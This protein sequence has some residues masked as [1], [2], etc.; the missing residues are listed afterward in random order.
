MGAAKRLL[1]PPAHRAAVVQLLGRRVRVLAELDLRDGR[2]AREGHA[3][4]AADDPLFREARVEHARAAELLLQSQRRPVHAAFGP[5]VLSEHHELGIRCELHIQRAANRGQ[6]V[7]AGCFGLRDFQRDGAANES[8]G[9]QPALLLHIPRS[10]ALGEHM[11]C[12]ASTDRVT[13]S[14]QRSLDSL[15][16]VAA[17]PLRDAATIHRR[18]MMF[19]TSADCRCVSGSRARSARDEVRR[20][21]GLGVLPRMPA[22]P[23]HGETQKNRA[24][25]GA[26]LRDTAATMS[27][28][29]LLRIRPVS[30]ENA[31]IRKRRE[32]AAMLPPGVCRSDVTEMP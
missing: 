11:P 19:G 22:E 29:G 28:R 20:L 23:R 1:R 9:C 24:C 15:L 8:F 25:V 5:N 4:R 10:A 27:W 31:E 3:D 2:K 17:R 7:D 26:H 21:V 12:N 14:I 30:I 32:I 6:H 13:P 16:N 18:V